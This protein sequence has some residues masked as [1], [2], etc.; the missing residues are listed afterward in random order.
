VVG[1]GVNRLFG[2]KDKVYGAAQISGV[3]GSDDLKSTT[4]YTQKGGTFRSDKS[5]S[6][7]GA[8]DSTL[9]AGLKAGYDALK[10]ASADYAKALGLD[11]ASIATRTDSISFS[12]GKSAEEQQANIA[13]MFQGIGDSIAG[14]LLG[15]LGALQKD[16]EQASETLARLGTSITAANLWLGKLKINLFGVSTSGADAASKLA[17]A[18][19]GLQNMAQASQSF[20]ELYYTEAERA[21][22]SNAEMAVSLALVNLAVPESKEQFKSLVGSLD[23][24]TE[25][26]RKAYVALM[27]IAPVFSETS[28]KLAELSKAA[29][30]ALLSA[31][32]G[33]GALIPALDAASLKT[34]NF[35]LSVLGVGI[36]ASGTSTKFDA[37][38]NGIAG[39][40]GVVGG[41]VVK[42]DA[43]TGSLIGTSTAI[44][45]AIGKIDSAGNSIGSIASQFLDASAGLI[46]FSDAASGLSPKMTAAQ[47]S[48]A[49]LTDQII[50]LKQSADKAKIDFAGLGAAMAGLDTQTFI[51]TMGLVFEN[52]GN[53]IKGVIESI[54]T[55][56][57]ALRE[58]ALQ[59]VNPTVLSKDA[60]QRGIAGINTA[61]PSNAGIVQAAQEVS[62]KDAAILSAQ[63]ALDVAR[64]TLE[65]AQLDALWY[66][67]D[68]FNQYAVEA[69]EAQKRVAAATILVSDASAAVTAAQAAQATSIDRTKAA[70][71]AYASALQD[72]T[73]DAS[74]SVGRLSKLREETLKY[75][76]AQKQLA[77][78]MTNS[79]ANLRGTV[80]TYKYDQ[81][82]PEQQFAELQA[83]Y[84]SSYSMALSTSGTDLAGYGDKLNSMLN[85]LLEKAKEIYGSGTAYDAFVATTIARADNIAGRLELLTP[86]NYAADSLSMLGQIDATLVALDA[87]SKSAE[88][89]ISDA[90]KA[91]ADQTSAGLHA[92]VAALTGQAVPAFAAGGDFGGGLR[93]VGENGPELEATG[94]S[95]IFNAE[96]T[97]SMLSGGS[98]TAKLEALVAR[99]TQELANMRA[100]L[101]AIATTNNKMLKLADRAEKDGMLIRNE[102]PITTVAA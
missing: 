18:F 5:G 75:Y 62:A 64:S 23:L 76:E 1:G 30:V 99:Q 39:I 93:L 6:V 15:N 102:E 97:R 27:A 26:G 90:I 77:D 31:F 43:A 42:F 73:I 78:L 32:T 56:R 87:A 57:V 46:D 70:Q 96:Q 34:D 52:L 67:S 98:S 95:R 53:R 25:A 11:A 20:Y 16:G 72:F 40:G 69:A 81:L 86:T 54:S 51:N 3:L 22:Q 68:Y 74:K 10:S 88:K 79:A 24:N 14:G 101:R 8:A 9:S 48:A 83:K 13:K 91:G 84:A 50:G 41:V 17:D 45:G 47:L 38:A 100:E 28:A 36:A 55:E 44:T 29:A 4:G 60:I 94:A 92:I 7:V 12:V 58:A 71:L 49:L 33:N 35:G 19:G 80:A 37:A 89:I 61:L 65:R 85:P 2:Y 63:S 21:A 59:I 82:S 66:A